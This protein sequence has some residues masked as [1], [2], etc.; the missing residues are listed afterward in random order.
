MHAPPELA[1]PTQRSEPSWLATVPLALF[2]FGIPLDVLI[3]R[4]MGSSSVVLGAPLVAMVCWR[5]IAT[6]RLRPLPGSLLLLVLFTGWSAASLLWARDTESFLIALKT[7]AQLLL[8]AVLCWQVLDSERALRAV[9]AGYVGG[10][11]GAV[12]SVWTAFL[13]GRAVGD[14]FY[15]GGTRFVAEAF[16]P[17]DM[18]VTLAIGIPMAA[19]LALA[20]RW[21]GRYVALGYVPLAWSAIALSGS[22]G[23]TIAALVA[24]SG[25]LAW[26]ALRRRAA[27]ALA[28]V[29][30]AAG[31]ALTWSI[32]P[33]DT[34]SRIFTVREQLAAGGTFGE[35]V[36][37]WRAG[38]GL[39]A[40]HPVV[41]TGLG[42]FP[43]AIVPFL[44]VRV[45][46]HSTFLSVAVELGVIG[47]VLYAGAFAMGAREVL[48]R[49]ADQAGLGLTLLL[50]WVA[51]SASLSWAHRKT[52]WLVLLVCAAVGAMQRSV[53]RRGAA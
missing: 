21:R 19:Y 10:C 36:G 48:R 6:T 51:G 52:T 47:L 41:G 24:V 11:I 53:A 4:R 31:V 3:A 39:F 15:E 45:V 17:N 23:A 28:L 5:V 26:L 29:L 49:S 40:R 7:T 25:L 16:D 35:R 20:G 43:D 22:R 12:A 32:V 38:L 37:I 2:A 46:A 50:A 44:G 33:W 27:L 18:G 1:G 30:L 34:W 8:F 14:E 13:E 9:L 42:G